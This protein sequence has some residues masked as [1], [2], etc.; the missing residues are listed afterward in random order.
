MSSRGNSA[1]PRPLVRTHQAS[2]ALRTPIREIELISNDAMHRVSEIKLIRTDTTLDLSQKAEKVCLTTTKPQLQRV[3]GSP[4][5]DESDIGRNTYPNRNGKGR[6][7]SLVGALVRAG[8][9]D[10]TS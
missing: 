6:V 8:S 2:L 10:K 7:Q 9:V 4:A 1:T 5:S 3:C